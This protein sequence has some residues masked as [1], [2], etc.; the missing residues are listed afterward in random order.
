MLAPF[1]EGLIEAA[2]ELG[3]VDDRSVR[4]WFREPTGIARGQLRVVGRSPVTGTATTSGQIDWTGSSG[5]NSPSLHRAKR[6][7]VKSMGTI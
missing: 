5:S 7:S 4:I 2:Y 1:P 6:S 3:A